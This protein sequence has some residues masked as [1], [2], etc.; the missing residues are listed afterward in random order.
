MQ[1][2]V[3]LEGLIQADTSREVQHE[4][5]ATQEVQGSPGREAR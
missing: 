4:Q 1:R 3:D 5:G 2:G